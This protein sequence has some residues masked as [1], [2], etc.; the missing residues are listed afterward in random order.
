MNGLIS[1]I[2][3]FNYYNEN[4]YY[5]SLEDLGISVGI[6]WINNNHYVLQI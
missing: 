4:A 6:H 5:F 1:F 3:I 2:I